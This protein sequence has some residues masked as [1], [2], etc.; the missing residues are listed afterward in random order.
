[1]EKS[2]LLWVILLISIASIIINLYQHGGAVSYNAGRAADLSGTC[3]SAVRTAAT[4]CKAQGYTSSACSEASTAA[5]TA[6]NITIP[7]ACQ[8]ALDQA[9]AICDAQ[10]Q[11]SQ[12]CR[13][14]A[15]SAVFACKN[16]R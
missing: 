8:T 4:A 15:R 11:S 2:S 14:T 6:C 9:S 16:S 7:A 3:Q 10:G 12:A 13:D 5:A 1:M